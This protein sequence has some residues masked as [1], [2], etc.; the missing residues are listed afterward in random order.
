MSIG[1]KVLKGQLSLELILLAAAL[2]LFVGVISNAELAYF[3]TMRGKV[4]LLGLKAVADGSCF[5]FDYLSFNGKNTLISSSG[6]FNASVAG[7]LLSISNGRLNSTAHCIH[8]LESGSVF[9]VRQEV[10]EH[11]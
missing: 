11:V 6:S 10:F 8:E 7:N 4:D 1:V 3:K 5:L 9:K 2:V